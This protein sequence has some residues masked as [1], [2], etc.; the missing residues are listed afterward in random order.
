MT[1]AD[2]AKLSPTISNALFAFSKAFH[3]SP[4]EK[5]LY[6]LVDMRA[7]QMNGCLFCL[8]MHA[9]Q[10]R[11]YG[12]RELRLHHLAVWRES[13][14]FSAREKAALEYTERMTRLDGHPYPDAEYAKLSEH[15][16]EREIAD[17]GLRIGLINL[18]NRL[19]VTFQP[20]PGALDQAYG[21][22]KIGLK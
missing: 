10:A 4:V 12:D 16:S 7:S 11:T 9:K 13:S 15:F 18:W 20:K 8:D 17:L 22:D 6:A 21:L 19:G 1:R 3:D 14:L 2:Y 5:E